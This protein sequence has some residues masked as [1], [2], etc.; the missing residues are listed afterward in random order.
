MRATARSTTAPSDRA[1]P[2]STRA[3]AIHSKLAPVTFTM[4]GGFVLQFAALMSE[5]AAARSLAEIV[6]LGSG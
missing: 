3:V 2:S 5:R 1:I 6:E 4:P